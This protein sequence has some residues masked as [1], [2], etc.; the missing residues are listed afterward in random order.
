MDD[1]RTSLQALQTVTQGRTTDAS[2]SKSAT[3]S[4]RLFHPACTLRS[5]S[6]ASAL[7]SLSSWTSWAK[8]SERTSGG[9]VGRR[10]EVAERRS[11]RFVFVLMMSAIVISCWVA[12]GQ[13]VV[14][15][16]RL[17]RGGIP[18]PLPLL[19]SHTT[20]AGMSAARYSAGLEEYI[21]RCV[22]AST[23]HRRPGA[24]AY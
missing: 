22:L 19:D 14:P 21:A 9:R 8:T 15:V 23:R 24:W 18:L 12:G 2:P 11:L 6:L 13:A 20:I 5:A 3:E 4:S 1:E 16:M 7:S 17:R 10:E